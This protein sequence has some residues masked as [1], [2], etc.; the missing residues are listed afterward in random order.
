[1]AAGSAGEGAGSNTELRW[2]FSRLACQSEME[3]AYGARL[4]EENFVLRHGSVC[5]GDAMGQDVEMN[6]LI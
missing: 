5:L 3:L 1:M 2:T 6:V 4:G